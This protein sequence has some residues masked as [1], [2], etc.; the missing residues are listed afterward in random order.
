MNPNAS[1]RSLI[2]CTEIDAGTQHTYRGSKP[3]HSNSLAI[4]PDTNSSSFHYVLST[5]LRFFRSFSLI[6]PVYYFFLSFLLNFLPYL[7]PRSFHFF[8]PSFSLF[9]PLFDFSW[10]LIYSFISFLY[11]L[12]DGCLPSHTWRAKYSETSNS[13]PTGQLQQKSGNVAENTNTISTFRIRTRGYKIKTAASEF[14]PCGWQLEHSVASSFLR[15][16]AL[17]NAKSAANVAAKTYYALNQIQTKNIYKKIRVL[18]SQMRTDL[19][20]QRSLTPPLPK[21]PSV[22]PETHPAKNP[23]SFSRY[24][25]R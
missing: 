12:P 8:V 19:R 11:S 20:R 9:L 25:A 23:F 16:S 1:R 4:Q 14:G 6:S 21:S 3:V 2:S 18:H 22:V 24:R 5:F 17:S 10:F 13:Q 7:F 15:V